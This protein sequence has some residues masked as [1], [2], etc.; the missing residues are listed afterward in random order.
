MS[1][2]RNST[3]LCPVC[4]AVDLTPQSV[5]GVEVS[6]CRQCRG[7]FY[8]AEALELLVKSAIKGLAIK[9]SAVL[10][11]RRC[12]V[13]QSAMKHMTYPQTMVE[14]EICPQCKGVWLDDREAR[15]IEAVREH[16]R[17]SGKLLQY[18]AVPGFKGKLIRLINHSIDSLSNYK[19]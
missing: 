7:A 8:E 14:I 4:R 10:T 13:D 15:E 16:I 12:P 2:M 9:D 11:D 6:Y 3:M 5:K 19:K 1:D 17:R 18:D